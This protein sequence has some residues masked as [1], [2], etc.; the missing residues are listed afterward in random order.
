IHHCGRCGGTWLL[1]AQIAPL[2]AVSASAV[3]A[4]ITRAAEAGFLCHGCHAP[5]ERD[6][7]HCPSCSCVNTLECPSCSKWMRRTSE[8]DV[9]VDVCRGCEAVWLDHHELSALWTAAA[10]LAV[11]H[12]GGTNVV[13]AGADAGSFLLDALW[14]APDLTVGAVRGATYLAGEG[15]EL[16]SH[17]AGAGL[18]A[19]SNAP[20]LF[21]G[22]A[23]VLEAAGDVAGAVFGLIAEV[24]GGIFG[25]LG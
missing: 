21:S 4:M 22:L 7:A 15:M 23:N 9:T 11:V 18:E 24:I 3:R 17:A 25:G 16:T 6:A 13:A 20:G 1:R 19:V 2:R 12:G 5:M 10:A 14:Y 8:R